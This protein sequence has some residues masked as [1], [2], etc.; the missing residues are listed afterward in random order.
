MENEQFCSRPEAPKP[1]LF[2]LT[3]VGDGK[4][5]LLL[6]CQEELLTFTQPIRGKFTVFYILLNL[7]CSTAHPFGLHGVLYLCE[8]ISGA[9]PH[10]V[11]DAEAGT[12]QGGTVG[13]GLS[14][15]NLSAH[16]S[17]ATQAEVH[18]GP[19]YYSLPWEGMRQGPWF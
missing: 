19:G 17:K 15:R 8:P 3:L 1:L 14:R 4:E 7:H 16:G 5:V 9:R 2:S 18:R 6:C 11:K 12:P 13:T 10:Q